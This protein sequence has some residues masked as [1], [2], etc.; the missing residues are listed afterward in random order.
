MRKDGAGVSLS[1]KRTDGLE[2]R[3]FASWA[4]P[5][6]R[7]G[8]RISPGAVSWLLEAV[9]GSGCVLVGVQAP[10]VSCGGSCSSLAILAD[11]TRRTAYTRQVPACWSVSVPD[12]SGEYSV[13]YSHSPD[14]ADL[15]GIGPDDSPGA[16]AKNGREFPRVRLVD[17]MT[18]YAADS[19][20]VSDAHGVTPGVA[21][22][23]FHRRPRRRCVRSPSPPTSCRRAYI[24]A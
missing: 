4:V 13:A 21:P 5:G 6:S 16:N 2:W 3:F 14:R 24:P 15:D 23:G 20:Q 18:Y 19:F 12:R 10:G 22:G 17:C 9:F 8:Y 7:I 1:Q 11:V